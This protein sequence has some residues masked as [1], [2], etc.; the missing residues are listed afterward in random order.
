VIDA[1]Q[2][3]RDLSAPGGDARP[4]I[5]GRFGDIS[6]DQLRTLVFS[7]D[8]ARRD[9]E[10][11]LHPLVRDESERRMREHADQGHRLVIYEAALLLE[12]GRTEGF[13]GLIVVIAGRDEQKARL[14]ARANPVDEL[15]AE[16]ILRAQWTDEQRRAKA[17]VLIENQGPVEALRA[18]VES[19]LRDRGLAP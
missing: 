9:L 18:P 3:V 15:T 2:I 8:R 7:D 10:A 4:L 12:T 17:T 19:F 16:R 5:R 13:Q 1:D 6:K 14:L 11:I